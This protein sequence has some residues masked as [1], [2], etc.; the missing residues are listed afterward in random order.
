M[1]RISAFE[2]ILNIS[3]ANEKSAKPE[4]NYKNYVFCTFSTNKF[5]VQSNYLAMNYITTQTAPVILTVLIK[6]I[7]QLLNSK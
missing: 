3:P 7:N 1:I 5:V 4:I 2:C 6:I